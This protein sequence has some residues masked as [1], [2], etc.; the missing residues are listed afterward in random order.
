LVVGE[1]FFRGLR[2]RGFTSAGGGHTRA[3]WYEDGEGPKNA[4]MILNVYRHITA[5]FGVGF[6]HA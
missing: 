3:R 5:L 4:W 2:E 6:N 1:F